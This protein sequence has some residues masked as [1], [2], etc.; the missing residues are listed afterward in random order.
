MRRKLT[1]LMIGATI[2]VCAC[3]KDGGHAKYPIR[4]DKP[5]ADSTSAYLTSETWMLHRTEYP[6]GPGT[7]GLI[8]D[9]FDYNATV[10]D[11]AGTFTISNGY[12]VTVSGT[13]ALSGRILSLTYDGSTERDTVDEVGPSALKLVIPKQVSAWGKFYDHYRVWYIAKR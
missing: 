9:A 7:W 3:T 10:F 6:T 8:S 11:P 1:G 13:W 12:A 4:R 2:A 5:A